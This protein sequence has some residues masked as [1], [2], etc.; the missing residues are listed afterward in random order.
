MALTSK[1]ACVLH[2]T[3]DVKT[4]VIGTLMSALYC[5]YLC[6]NSSKFIKHVRYKCKH[7]CIV[8]NRCDQP[9]GDNMYLKMKKKIT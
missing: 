9:K 2:H 6:I 8:F 7:C 5:I 4:I 1:E 3:G